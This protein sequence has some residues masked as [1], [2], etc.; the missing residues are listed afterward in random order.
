[1]WDFSKERFMEAKNK[2]LLNGTWDIFEAATKSGAVV[3]PA[4]FMDDLLTARRLKNKFGRCAQRH[5]R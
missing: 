2:R 1:M 3:D 4:Q 5:K